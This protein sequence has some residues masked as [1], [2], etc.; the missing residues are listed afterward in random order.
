MNSGSS[1]PAY[2]RQLLLEG[3][4]R[5]VVLDLTE[6]Q[7]YGIESWGDPDYVCIYGLRPTACGLVRQRDTDFRANHSGVYP[8]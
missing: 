2:D 5:N 7:R 4:K 1:G 3:T 6:V 8:R